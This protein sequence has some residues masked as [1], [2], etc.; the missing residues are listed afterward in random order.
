MGLGCVKTP[1]SNCERKVRLDFH[2][3]EKQKRWRRC[4]DKTIE[5][6]FCAL[7]V[8]ARFHAARVNRVFVGTSGCGA[9]RTFGHAKKTLHPG[10][11]LELRFLAEIAYRAK[12][13]LVFEYPR[14]YGR[15]PFTL[16]SFFGR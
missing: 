13:A 15:K 4:R 6:Q 10:I 1:E 2:Q 5:K 11:W 3:F 8:R 16:A 9:K 12:S 7:F 14:L